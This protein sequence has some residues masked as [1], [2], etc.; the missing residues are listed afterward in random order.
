MYTFGLAPATVDKQGN[1]GVVSPRGSLNLP[2]RLL[3]IKTFLVV[4]KHFLECPVGAS[5]PA[6]T[7]IVHQYAGV[8]VVK[9]HLKPTE[10][11][12]CCVGV[13]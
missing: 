11:V 5:L 8:A 4:A 7:P 10:D 6:A 13:G 12:V 9:A 1:A 3:L 2:T